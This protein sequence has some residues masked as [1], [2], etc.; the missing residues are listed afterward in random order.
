MGTRFLPVFIG[1]LLLFAGYSYGDDSAFKKTKPINNPEERTIIT[2]CTQTWR[3]YKTALSKGDIEEALK[4]VSDNSKSSFRNALQS[5]RRDVR[6]GEISFE[7]LRNNF[8]RFKMTVQA[9]LASGDDIPPGYSPGDL[10]KSEGYVVF[11]KDSGGEWK[12]DF[13]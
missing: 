1:T 10:F 4:N 7:S 12:I 8:A 9:K 6:L 2:Q 5:Q 13:Y 3:L 11:V